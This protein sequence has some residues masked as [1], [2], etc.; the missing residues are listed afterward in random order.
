MA[1][2]KELYEKAFKIYELN[3]KTDNQ[4]HTIR[5]YIKKKLK[6]VYNKEWDKLT[7]LEQERFLYVIIRQDMLDRYVPEGN[8]KKINKK[9][10]KY[11]SDS[12]LI[13]KKLIEEFNQTND[14]IRTNYDL[15]NQT[16][17]A[18]K[19]RYNHFC[20]SL[21]KKSPNTT[22]PSFN[23]WCK[24]PI[25]AYSYLNSM[26][27]EE[28]TSQSSY[29]V[30]ESEVDHV[31]I[32]TLVKALRDK[33]NIDIDVDLIKECL[34]YK[35]DFCTFDPFDPIQTEVDPNINMPKDKQETI[36]NENL[37]YFRHMRILEALDFIK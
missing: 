35:N 13:E 10:D 28:R 21:N 30:S 1:K 15:S 25:S 12:L 24:N 3:N 8:H 20:N 11:L 29:N 34:Q 23:E 6:K 36:I 27:S 14:D 18:K 9:I 17:E 26:Y 19:E 2:R 4:E 32:K 16:D 33:Q 37:E 7:Q 22:P 31:I 5:N